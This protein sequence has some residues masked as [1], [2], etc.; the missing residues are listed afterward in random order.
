MN[1]PVVAGTTFVALDLAPGTYRW[2]ACGRSRT[3]PFCD[4][5]HVGTG[6]EPVTFT[7]DA[8]KRCK[9]CLCKQTANAPFCDSS[10]NQL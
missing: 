10:H 3:Q 4:D 6:I 9:L 7:V 5:S 1:T 8:P 2:C